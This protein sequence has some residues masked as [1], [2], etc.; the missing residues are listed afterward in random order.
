MSDHQ[1]TH[2]EANQDQTAS[3]SQGKGG[4]ERKRQ[5]GEHTEHGKSHG[6]PFGHDKVGPEPGVDVEGEDESS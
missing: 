5:T 4:G 6:A 1:S 3:G 2:P